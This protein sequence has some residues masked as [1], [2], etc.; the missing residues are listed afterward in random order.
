MYIKNMGWCNINQKD[1]KSRIIDRQIE[2]Y[3][4]T[5]GTIGIEESKWGGGVRHG[6][7]LITVTVRFI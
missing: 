2:S 1:Y 3:L 6:I 7:L 5:F 4:S